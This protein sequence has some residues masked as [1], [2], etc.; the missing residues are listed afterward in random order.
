MDNQDGKVFATFS[1]GRH[2]RF[3]KE[4]PSIVA[5]AVD[6]CMVDPRLAQVGKGHHVG[7]GQQCF[8]GEAVGPVV[9]PAEHDCVSGPAFVVG[10]EH[11]A[12]VFL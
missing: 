9:A 3:A 2:K 8:V 10:F 1:D 12:K 11:A 4:A 6:A 5:R 7:V